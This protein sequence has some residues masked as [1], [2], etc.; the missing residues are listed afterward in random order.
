LLKAKQAYFLLNFFENKSEDIKSMHLR[1]F[2]ISLQRGKRLNQF[3]N[4]TISYFFYISFKTSTN[5]RFSVSSLV[6]SIVS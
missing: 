6:G 3:F 5:I 2:S 1:G 4:P